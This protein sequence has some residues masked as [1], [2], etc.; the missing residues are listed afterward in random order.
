MFVL[1]FGECR[2]AQHLKVSQFFGRIKFSKI[3]FSPDGERECLA[4]NAESAEMAR[5]TARS[6]SH[7]LV[8]G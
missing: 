5:L 7:I 6:G 8:E 2:L 1:V 3:Y 4:E